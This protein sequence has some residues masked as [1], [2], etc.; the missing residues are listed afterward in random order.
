MRQT[1]VGT[2]AAVF[3]VPAL[4]GNG[5]N[6]IGFGAESVLMGGADVA[7]ARDTSALNTNPAGL[8]QIDR[9][10]LDIFGSVA[11]GLDVRH[12]DGFGN[13]RRVDNR[14]PVLGSFGYAA[15]LPDMPVTLGIGFFAQGG[16]GVVYKD[17]NTAFGTVDE[18]S[19]IFRI[20]RL[21][22]G[23]AWQATERLAL[24]VS[25]PITYSD[26]QQKVFPGTSV[27]NAASPA[28]SFFGFELKDAHTVRMGFKL[29]AQYRVSESLMLGAAY[30]HRTR[31]P[32]SGGRLTAN[33]SA[34]GLGQVT[35]RDARVDGLALPR[36]VS[37]GFA[38]RPRAGWLLSF[39]YAWI[40][41]AHSLRTSTLT[42]SNPG[43]PLAPAVLS[44]VAAH[45][46]R[47]QNVFAFGAEI[48]LSSRT[49]LRMGYNYGRNPI[50]AR[51]LNPLLAAIGEHHLSVGVSQQFD[52]DWKAWTLAYGME[53]QRGDKA[54]YTN[55][56]LPFGP[57]AEARSNYPVFDLML[58]RR[59]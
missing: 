36:E 34:I 5:L 12:R 53:Y 18:L 44:S 50:P 10:A 58:S 6:L 22:P 56:A 37:L 8:A 38:W 15:R 59:W 30:A 24:G 39:K 48:G 54:V 43:N 45:Y 26:A 11:Y 2:L 32:L 47:N 13:D 29:G 14:F 40:N 23:A 7:V 41:W 1:C 31:L 9:R 51:N 52:G 20:A 42:A 27:F 17:L 57:N 55:R 28:A 35:Y 21:S 46:W 16:A 25:A 19:G 49:K 33:M 3:S 4:A